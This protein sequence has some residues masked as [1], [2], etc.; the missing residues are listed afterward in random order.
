MGID[1]V[2][3]LDRIP[4]GY[5][6]YLQNIRVIEEGRIESRPGYSDFLTLAGADTPNSIRRLNDAD[7]SFASAGYIFVGGGGSNLYAGIPGAYNNVDSGY[8]GNP[9]T[10]ITFRPDQ[11][12]ESWM[13]VYD[14]SKLSKVRPDG[15]V[16]NQGIAPPT[17]PPD[18]DYGPPATVL[19]AE[20]DVGTW[21]PAGSATVATANTDR[22]FGSGCT[23]NSILYNSGTT[24]WA[25]INPIG[26]FSFFWS[27]ERMQVILNTGGGNKETVT[28]RE[29]HPAITS[30]TIQAI[31]YDSG[32]T[33]PCS[34]VLANT[35]LPLERNSLIRIGG[36][37]TVRV[38]SSTPSADG[39]SYSIRCSTASTHAAADAVAGLLSW[40]VYTTV[41]HVATETIDAK[42]VAVTNPASGTGT[43]TRTSA[44]NA[45]QASGRPI[46]QADD[47]MHISIFIENPALVTSVVLKIDTGNA[48][49]TKNYWT[50]TIPASQLSP[51]TLSFTDLNIPLSSGVLTGEASLS[52]FAT[53]SA[54][55]VDLVATAACNYG[56]ASWYLFGTYGPEVAQNSP[57][58]I[59]Y[60]SRFRD[61]TTGAKSV[62]GPQTRYE[63][64]PLREEILVTPQ[65]SNVAG[66]DEIDVYRLG[67]TV[68]QFL[69]V[70]SV[71][72][73]FATPNTYADALPDQQVLEAN[74]PP[75][76]NVFQP[77]PI[78]VLPWSG[79]VN[80]VGTT[81]EWVSGT[82]FDLN[83]LANTVILINGTAYQTFGQP[84]TSTFLEI[85]L[86]GGVLTNATFQVASPTLAAQPLP[87]AFLLEGPFQPTVFALGDPINQG[88][89]YF[90]NSGDADSSSDQNTLELTGPSE[91]LISGECWNGLAFAGSRENIYLIRYSFLGSPSVFQWNK[92]PTPS[93]FWTRWAVCTTPVGI[94]FLGR[95]GIYIATDQGAVSIS[96]MLY[97]LFPHDGQ[98]A[99]SVIVDDFTFF[100][101]DMT[102]QKYLRL[103]YTDDSIIFS[104]LDTQGKSQCLRYQISRKRWFPL[105]FTDAIWTQYLVEGL[106]PDQMQVLLLSKNTTKV[107][108]EGGN[109]DSGV[110]FF[111]AAILPSSDG[112][113]ERGQKLYV[114]AMVQADGTGTLLM[115]AFYDNLQTFSPVIN[116]SL[117]GQ[118]IQ[119]SQNISSLSDL[120]L[121]RNIAGGFSWTGGPDGPRIYAWEPSGYIQ[122]YL[123]T[124]I[125]TQ[126]IN[127]GFT[128]WKHFRRLYAGLISN[129]NVLFTIK[130][131]DG[132]TYG[133]YTIP[134]TGG[135][136]KVF[137]SIVDHGAKAL[138]FAFELDG[139]SQ[140]FALFPEAF[141]LQTK[142][143]TEPTYIDLAVFKA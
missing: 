51:A 63:L 135:Q 57:V 126:Y 137:P 3:P 11:S 140:N 49:F 29:I 7:K 70:G 36:T 39:V 19:I 13:Y 102:Q 54:V 71:A 89:L 16:R 44:I 17:Y 117:T 43:A 61:S 45:S 33:G 139:Q 4:E 92:I 42:Y 136:F 107:Y 119:A 104:Y 109:K 118:V 80:V 1:L 14:S 52:S 88:T 94:A 6:P 23:I 120:T 91:P 28:V 64:F 12:P 129:G 31:Q 34:I 128:D 84:R 99:K 125:V 100:P 2:H 111:A 21:V 10:L 95:D 132:R 73:N 82:H 79:V 87:L 25:C 81:V 86:S 60:E 59:S 110:D 106:V 69:Y 108:L 30:T 38:L 90:S 15:V 27:G 62:T 22:T 66:V 143:W 93:G 142:S 113:D 85:V 105:M 112:G 26:T 141:T 18:A 121:Y 50:Y 9:L 124:K 114:D 83:L 5:F 123:S 41:N 122:P 97:P 68:S 8:S 131:D 75:D 37:E 76:L 96:D 74:Q 130:T 46:S 40:Y 115:R 58:G 24:G 67:A 48:S 134:S 101:V 103:A 116:I 98:A 78:Q 72:N 55:Q 138:A 56:F 53:I 20:G 77:W 35:P 47:W 133:P 65:A 32:T 127:L